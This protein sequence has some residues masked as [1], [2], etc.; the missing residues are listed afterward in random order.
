[1]A[2]D[3]SHLMIMADFGGVGSLG[4]EARDFCRELTLEVRKNLLL[5]GPIL[6]KRV[7]D[8][9]LAL[10]LAIL[11]AP[12]LLLIVI[13]IKLESRG[14]AFYKHARIGRGERTI[15]V[16]KFR[17]MMTHGDRVLQQYLERHPELAKEW[18]R[19]Q[20]LKNDPRVTRVGRFLRRTSLD[21]LP[22]LWNVLKG[23]MS[24]VGPRPIVQSEVQRY[25]ERF[26]LYRQ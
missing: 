10:V 22:Q 20:K 17:S 13:L 9:G 24:L 18:E 23:E 8:I 21:E 1:H 14:P 12:L 15:N 5:P 26:S 4:A 25:G 3:F 7:M 16:W 19:D 6:A 11:A 2:S